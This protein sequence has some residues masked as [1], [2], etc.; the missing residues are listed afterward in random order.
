[1]KKVLFLL[2]SALV[3]LSFKDKPSYKVNSAVLGSYYATDTSKTPTWVLKANLSDDNK[4]EFYQG[5][6]IAPTFIVAMKDSTH[7]KTPHEYSHTSNQITKMWSAKGAFIDN[8]QMELVVHI[9]D[10]T[11]ALKF[12]FSFDEDQKIV[13]IKR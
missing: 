13:Y 8:G 9:S 1:M 11:T 12:S 6:E 2:L 7:F 4:I 10:M 3:L 5:N